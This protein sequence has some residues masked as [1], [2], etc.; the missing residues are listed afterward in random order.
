[1]SF[2]FL[3]CALLL[4]PLVGFGQDPL[5]IIPQ[6]ASVERAGGVYRSGPLV[7][8]VPQPGPEVEAVLKS[9]GSQWSYSVSA[10]A[11]ADPPEGYH[12]TVE[13]QRIHITA[14]LGMG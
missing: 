5:S 4:L 13:T 8:T 1:M 9:F 14:V 11:V 6:P 2:K 7:V 12:L 10:G 3:R